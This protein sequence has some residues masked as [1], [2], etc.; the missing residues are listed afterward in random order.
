MLLIFKD[1]FISVFAV[2]LII[3]KHADMGDSNFYIKEH[4]QWR[5]DRRRAQLT[6]VIFFTIYAIPSKYSLQTMPYP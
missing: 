1:N 2:A 5:W 4:L 3:V 6:S